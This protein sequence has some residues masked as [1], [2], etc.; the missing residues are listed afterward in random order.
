MNVEGVVQMPKLPYAEWE[1]RSHKLTI[2]LTPFEYNGL[3]YCANQEQLRPA[4]LARLVLTAYI[5]AGSSRPS[6]PH[7][8]IVV[9]D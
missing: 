5:R 9:Q 4:E 3:Q 2:N 8:H 1:R 7:P 6:Y